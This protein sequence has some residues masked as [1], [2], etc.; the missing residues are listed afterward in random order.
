M[1]LARI[2]FGG[3]EYCME[4]NPYSLIGVHLIWRYSHDL[5]N[6]QIKATAKYTMYMVLSYM[7][8]NF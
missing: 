5:S 8:Q 6:R 4:R 2:L 3:F 1:Q 7:S